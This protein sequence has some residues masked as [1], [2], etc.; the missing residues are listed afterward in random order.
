MVLAAKILEIRQEATIQEIASK[1]SN[2][3]VSESYKVDDDENE[4][5]SPNNGRRY[6]KK[7]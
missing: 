7:T 5:V 1:L 3:R 6:R 4:L 2:F